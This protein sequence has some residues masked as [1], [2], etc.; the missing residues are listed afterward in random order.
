MA[1]A[2]DPHEDHE[3]EPNDRRAIEATLDRIEDRL[4]DAPDGLHSAGPPASVEAVAASG[5]REG[6]A[7]LWERW[8]GLDLAASDAV[9]L[10]L[11][12]QA[13]ATDLALGEGRIR[14]GDR[15][16]GERGRDLL[17]LVADPWAEGGDVAL[18][19]DDGTRLPY[20]STVERTVLAILGEIAVLYGDDG[21]FRD[22]LIGEDGELLPEIERRLLRRHLDFDPDAPLARFRLAKSLR[23]EGEVRGALGELKQLLRRAPEFAWAHHERGRVHLLA[24]DPR[25]A[26]VDF[27]NAARLAD[28]PGLRAYFMAW[29]GLASAGE[30]RQRIGKAVLEAMPGFPAAQEAGVRDALEVED[31]KRAE[32][33]LQLGLAIC[34]GHLGLLSL[35]PQVEALVAT[36]PAP[37]PSSPAASPSRASSP[38]RAPSPARGRAPAPAPAPRPRSPR[39]EAPA[40]GPGR[41]PRP[42][43]GSPR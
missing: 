4:R 16:I 8:D 40:G 1:R 15:V 14:A 23:Q 39:G 35:R 19:E 43:R 6:V 27:A 22:E 20:G 36:S 42:R 26:A 3:P 2:H 10:P 33:Q 41:R 38:S 7:M 12:A 25:L 13:D 31:G 29:Q 9:I 28:D 34:P 11:G 18:V 32:E 24:G 17:V 5:L 37:A 30:E 21:E